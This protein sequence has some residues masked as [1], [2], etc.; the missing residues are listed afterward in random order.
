MTLQLEIGRLR[1]D[2][3]GSWYGESDLFRNML[4][5]ALAEELKR[6]MAGGRMDAHQ[7]LRV[8]IPPVTMNDVY[9]MQETAREIARRIVQAIRQ[10]PG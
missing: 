9:D 4:E 5:R 7:V 8:D 2:A 3:P 6:A 1:I 10:N